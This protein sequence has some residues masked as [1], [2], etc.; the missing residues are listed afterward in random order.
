[1]PSIAIRKWMDRNELMMKPYRYF[2]RSFIFHFIR[3]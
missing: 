2:I 3:I 1:M